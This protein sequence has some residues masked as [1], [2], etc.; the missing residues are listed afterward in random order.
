M[1]STLSRRSLNPSIQRDGFSYVYNKLENPEPSFI[2]AA[3]IEQSAIDRM[4]ALQALSSILSVL[5]KRIAS[6]QTTNALQFL[7]APLTLKTRYLQD[8]IKFNRYEP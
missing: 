6:M 2:A 8:L 7:P 1:D 3:N 5:S 4:V